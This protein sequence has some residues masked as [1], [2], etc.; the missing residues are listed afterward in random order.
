MSLDLQP[1]QSNA[2]TTIPSHIDFTDMA[3]GST[4]PCTASLDAY[5]ET[6]STESSIADV[7]Q[8]VYPLDVDTLPWCAPD[9]GCLTERDAL[10]WQRP[11]L[12]FCRKQVF[13][14][15]L[16]VMGSLHSASNLQ[17]ICKYGML[18]TRRQ[19]WCHACTPH[20]V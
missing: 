17:V 7:A 16:F 1:G 3:S 4:E 15:Q 8:A 19:A 6:R 18:A 11:H 13:A 12:L 10:D 2:S 9:H 5:Q 14:R 20:T